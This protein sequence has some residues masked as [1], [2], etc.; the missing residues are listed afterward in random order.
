MNA[1]W[2]A[3]LDGERALGE[4][5]LPAGHPLLRGFQ[6]ALVYSNL[7]VSLA[8]TSLLYFAARSLAVTLDGRAYLL[9]FSASVLIYGLDH[10]LD[11]DRCEVPD[12]SERRYVRSRFMAGLIVLAALATGLLIF[13]V[14]PAVVPVLVPPGLIGL[15]YSVQMFPSRQ[16]GTLAWRRLKDLPGMK[17]V[18]VALA[19][20]L[21]VVGIPWAY[22]GYR[23]SWDLVQLALFTFAFL[24]T[25]THMFDVRDFETDRG[26]RLSTLACVLGPR[27][28][29]RILLL[30]NLTLSGL[31][32]LGWSSGLCEPRGELILLTALACLYVVVLNERSGRFA[33]SLFVDGSFFLPALFTLL[34]S[35]LS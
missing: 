7:W 4:E 14:P 29:K 12:P 26:R 13:L 34:G 18:L 28:V 6:A 30:A 31:L 10:L 35:A 19:L 8:V 2:T 1:P 21:G 3:E 23:V 15:L 5:A 33:Y 27:A 24:A 9:C 17:A 11:C 32:I 16:G 20:T 25:N 22:G